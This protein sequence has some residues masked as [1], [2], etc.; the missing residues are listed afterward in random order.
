MLLGS[1]KRAQ[2]GGVDGI[3]SRLGIEF[4]SKP[5]K[6]LRLVVDNREHS[7]KEEQI[8]RLQRLDVTAEWRWRGRELNTQLLQPALCAPLF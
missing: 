5:A 6:I 8:A 2:R 4:F 7:A 1:G 3:S